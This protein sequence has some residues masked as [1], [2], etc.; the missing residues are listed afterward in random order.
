[1]NRKSFLATVT[2]AM[3]APFAISKEVPEIK[4]ECRTLAEV[5][6]TLALRA[7]ERLHP[8]RFAKMATRE[9]HEAHERTCSEVTR[10]LL[11]ES[12][13]PDASDW[14]DRFYGEG[15]YEHPPRDA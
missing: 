14:L 2:A 6:E 15:K 12:G 7:A 10:K 3:A 8:E 13:K 4:T 11:M 9:I 5:F 1:M